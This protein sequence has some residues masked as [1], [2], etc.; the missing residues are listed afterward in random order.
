[1]TLHVRNFARA[2]RR[3]IPKF[4]YSPKKQTHTMQD[5]TEWDIVMIKVALINN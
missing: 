4:S 3:H 5:N 1:M 2:R